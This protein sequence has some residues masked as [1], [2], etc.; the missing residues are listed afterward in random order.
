MSVLALAAGFADPVHDAQAIFRAVMTAM[1]RPGTMQPLR[2]TLAPPAPLAPELAAVALALADH[3]TTIWLDAAL[4]QGREV[5]DFLAFHSGARRVADRSQATFA[6]VS[7]AGAVPPL[8]SFAQGTD[9]YP[10]RS[11]TV[12]V[13]VRG[14]SATAGLVLQGPG[15][16]ASV[17]LSIDPL[18]ATFVAERA[19]NRAAFPRGVDCVFVA[20]GQVA[21]LPRST[22]VTGG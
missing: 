11:T 13:A 6:L 18:P 4:A 12:V 14:L 2:T 1:A 19:A 22:V 20:P 3:E 5:S 15:I 17:R 7:G 8:A 16:K 21:A 10:D 9:E